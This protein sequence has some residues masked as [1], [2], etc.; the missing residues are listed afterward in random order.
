MFGDKSFHNRAGKERI[1]RVMRYAM[2]HGR[3]SVGMASSG[4]PGIPRE[5]L[6]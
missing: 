6:G 1:F 2:G 5:C 4:E 3:N